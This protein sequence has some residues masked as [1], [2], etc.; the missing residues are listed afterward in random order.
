MGEKKLTVLIGGPLTLY[1]L[2]H[3]KKILRLVDSLFDKIQVV[4][5]GDDGVLCSDGKVS[6]FNVGK[7]DGGS[8]FPAQLRIAGYLFQDVSKVAFL[9]SS[10]GDSDV[11]LF[12]GIYQPLPLVTVRLKGEYAVHFCGGFDVSYSSGGRS[13]FDEAF[14]RF[15]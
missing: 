15:R 5:E 13:F 7:S 9:F 8:G 2:A 6:V 3:L 10:V 1:R 14:L 12:L 11:V 4:Y